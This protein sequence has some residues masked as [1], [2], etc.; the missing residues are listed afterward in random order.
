[1]LAIKNI[2]NKNY[3]NAINLTN[4]VVFSKDLK[5]IDISRAKIAIKKF[6]V[7]INSDLRA[8]K[9]KK[10]KLIKFSSIEVVEIMKKLK[11]LTQII[12]K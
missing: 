10:I 2:C 1:M 12:K 4:K 6:F 7:D 8:V 9:Y 5:S 3:S 11:K